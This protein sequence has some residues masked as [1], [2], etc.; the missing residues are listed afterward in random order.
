MLYEPGKAIE[1]AT[2]AW[3]TDDDGL[4]MSCGNLRTLEA[5]DEIEALIGR[6]VVTSIESSV[7]SLH[8]QAGVAATMDGAG[9]LLRT[10]V[11]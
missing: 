2:A 9:L 6:L 3:H 8:R 11:G 4:V 7:W 1:L 5:I 10:P